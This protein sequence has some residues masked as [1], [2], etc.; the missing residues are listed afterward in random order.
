VVLL[1]T[2]V[3][4]A[5]VAAALAWAAWRVYA[6]LAGPAER[7]PSAAAAAADGPAAAEAALV[8][9]GSGG[10]GGSSGGGGGGAGGGPTAQRQVMDLLSSGKGAFS[11]SEGRAVANFLARQKDLLILAAKTPDADER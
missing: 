4:C 11:V 7:R 9:G 5:V 6:L 2:A 1:Y 8:G 3:G 10:G